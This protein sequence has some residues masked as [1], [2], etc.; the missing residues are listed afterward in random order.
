MK[1]RQVYEQA[2]Y[3][4][5]LTKQDF[6][7]FRKAWPTEKGKKTKRRLSL[8]YDTQIYWNCAVSKMSLNNGKMLTLKSYRELETRHFAH[9]IFPRTVYE[10]RSIY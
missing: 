2:V 8:F 4:D 5:T 6:R 3:W 7:L 10:Y 1:I 9:I